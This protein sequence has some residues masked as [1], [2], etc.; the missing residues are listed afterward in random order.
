[1]AP[2][3]SRRLRALVAAAIAAAIVAALAGALLLR[4]TH[5]SADLWFSNPSYA[6]DLSLNF[7]EKASALAA[8]N[9]ILFGDIDSN[10]GM[11]QPQALMPLGFLIHAGWY[12]VA[13]VSLA[14]TRLPFMILAALTLLAMTWMG[15]RQLAPPALAAF[16]VLAGWN[17]TLVAFQ[18]SCL[19]EHLL[20]TGLVVMALWAPTPYARPRALAA[21][22]LLACIAAAAKANGVVYAAAPV[23]ALAC[24]ALRARRGRA[25]R[26]LLALT[27]GVGAAAALT[28]GLYA[29][30]GFFRPNP[31]HDWMAEYNRARAFVPPLSG[32]AD[33]LTAF[34]RH[35]PIPA[36]T[37]R[38]LLLLALAAPFVL[39]E[40][41]FFTRAAWWG[42]ALA[43]VSGAPLYLYY[44][45]MVP[46]VPLVFYLAA[47]GAQG[48]VERARAGLSRRRQHASHPTAPR[49]SRAPAADLA[50]RIAAVAWG[51]A[52]VVA[53]W[54][55]LQVAVAG[56]RETIAGN[57]RRPPLPGYRAMAAILNVTI[58]PGT[59]L[60]APDTFRVV[61]FDTPFA[62]H[63]THDMVARHV[64]H[65]GL[66]DAVFRDARAAG[67]RV[68]LLPTDDPQDPGRHRFR[69]TAAGLAPQVFEA[70]AVSRLGSTAFALDRGGPLP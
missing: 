25:L 7:E 6:N 10:G 48:L 47:A 66:A 70:P 60:A 30:L 45:R 43:L 33:Y 52:A 32:I 36:G 31:F 26:P 62:Y 61:A 65:L 14:D 21:W 2:R 28:L 69:V 39:R 42:L 4:V 13:G 35:L 40:T 50:R 9:W 18:R 37:E 12:A 16:V 58:P 15:R 5:P 1:M 22:G 24:D 68:V 64:E 56:A 59:V 19:D 46:V 51:T 63:F 29:A 23:M 27:L 3:L 11:Y 67:A 17:A 44:K 41:T 57:P 34:E 54:I 20:L 53:A 55:V 8:R 38:P 49:E